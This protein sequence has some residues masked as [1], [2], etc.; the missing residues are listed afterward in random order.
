MW[1]CVFLVDAFCCC[2]YLPA[3]CCFI[4]PTVYLRHRNSAKAVKSMTPFEAWTRKKPKVGH[5]RVFGCDAYAHIPKDERH[6]L[7]SKARKYIFLGCGE[8]TK[9]YRL[10]DPKREKVI[11]SRDVQFN[12]E[13]KENE[14]DS[15]EQDLIERE[16]KYLIDLDFSEDGDTTTDECN[17]GPSIDDTAEPVLWRS[18]REI[19]LPDYYAVKVNTA[20]EKQ[21]DPVS[22]EEAVASP[23]Q[24][25]WLKAMKNEVQSL[26]D[27]DVWELVELPDGRKAVGS[28]WVY[29]VRTGADGSIECYKARLVVQGFSQKYGTDYDETFCPVVQLESLRALLPW[30]YSMI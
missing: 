19:H 30:Q 17:S 7:D 29:K 12:E 15:I 20:N 3:C 5:L 16:T 18:V 25:K 28:K 1:V 6:K 14:Q 4:L 2:R 10:Y 8:E 24:S 22:T 9:E 27:N 21:M 13:K 26:K 11:Y 23:E